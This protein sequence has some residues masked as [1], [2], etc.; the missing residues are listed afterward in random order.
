MEKEK[1][2][3]FCE[4]TEEAVD[5][6]KS[7]ESFKK[8]DKKP[9]WKIWTIFLV[10]LIIIGSLFL[11]K[12]R[13][14]LVQ[15]QSAKIIFE[16]SKDEDVSSD[17][18]FV[19]EDVLGNKV[20]LSDFKDK[21]P[22]LLVFWATWCGVCAEELPDLKAFDQA[23][24]DDI[25]VITIVSG[26]PIEVIKDYIQ[27]NDINF[28]VLLDNDR[29]VWNQYFPRGTPVHFLI[30]KQGIMRGVWPGLAS[31]NNL[32]TMLDSLK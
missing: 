23:Y 12:F 26:E 27:E 29:K 18:N 24:Y 5:K 6:L 8:K 31:M 14:N 17:L 21:K 19:L 4:I 25:Q 32:E 2:C 9:S 13:T 28:L 20:A 3:P 10:F 1:D 7:S 15:E 30:D 11:Y 22:V 16:N